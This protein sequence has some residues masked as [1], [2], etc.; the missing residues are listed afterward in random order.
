MLK[1]LSVGSGHFLVPKR[2]KKR[3]QKGTRIWTRFW[4][5]TCAKN[6]PKIDTTIATKRLLGEILGSSRLSWALLGHQQAF[7]ESAGSTMI[8]SSFS[9]RLFGCFLG[10]FKPLQ[11]PYLDFFGSIRGLLGLLWA[12][13]GTSSAML[14]VACK[15]LEIERHSE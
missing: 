1:V 12:A 10:S 6:T 14:S 9:R 11:G 4:N 5:Q 3:H 13:S 7:F 15:L 8:A 2:S